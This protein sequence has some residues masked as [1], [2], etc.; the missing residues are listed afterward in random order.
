MMVDMTTGATH[1]PASNAETP[2]IMKARVKVPFWNLFSL[3]YDWNFE[4]SRRNTSNI[5]NASRKN[6]ILIVILNQVV[7]FM[8]PKVLENPRTIVIPSPPYTRAIPAP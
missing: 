4:K 3:M 5:A 2:P 7:E 8:A 1:A 6:N